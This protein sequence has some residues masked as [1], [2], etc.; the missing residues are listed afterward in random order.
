MSIPNGCSSLPTRDWLKTPRRYRS[1]ATVFE[2][3]CFCRA[4]VATYR[5][6]VIVVPTVLLLITAI[7]LVVMFVLAYCH[8]E[9]ASASALP[10]YSRSRHRQTRHLQGIDGKCTS[11]TF[12]TRWK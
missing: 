6:D 5:L 11:S 12:R 10:R 8:R 2:A 4:A 7:T 9:R 3:L 1:G